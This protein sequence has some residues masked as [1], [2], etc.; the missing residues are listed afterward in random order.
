[1]IERHQVK[2]SAE[3]KLASLEYLGVETISA[4][5]G[6]SHLEPQYTEELFT[7][8]KLAI[9]CCELQVRESALGLELRFIKNPG[10]SFRNIIDE[11]NE[12]GERLYGRAIFVRGSREIISDSGIDEVS[13][14]ALSYQIVPVVPDTASRYTHGD[15]EKIL[16]DS[17]SVIQE[18]LTDVTQEEILK[19]NNLDWV[20]R[21]LLAA[22]AGAYR[23]HFGFP[24]EGGIGLGNPSDY[25]D[26]FKGAAVF[27]AGAKAIGSIEEGI[28]GLVPGFSPGK[29]K[30]LGKIEFQTVAAG[31]AH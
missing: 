28:V 25:G 22:A 23:L 14:T 15:L 29:I 10:F 2:K 9:A 24:K 11:I 19:R 20:S 3:E 31:I 1:M 21:P 16:S 6:L 18:L 4:S 8:L 17:W 5:V 7:P 27:C 30:R 13:E 26:L 12:A